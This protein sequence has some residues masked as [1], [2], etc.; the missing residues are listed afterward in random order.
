VVNPPFMG[1]RFSRTSRSPAINK[2]GTLYW[3]F[4]LA[5]G[6]GSLERAGHEV[7][8]LDC[9][10]VGMDVEDLAD[11]LTGFGPRMIVLD[12]STPSI[13][14]DLAIAS[15][16]RGRLPGSSLILVGTHCSALPE[17]CLRLAPT[18]SGVAIGEYDLTLVEAAEAL[19]GGDLADV[20]GMLV[21][22]D[23]ELV[24]TA[25]RPPISDLDSLPLLAD[26]YERHLAPEN[27]FFAAARYPSVMTI[28]SRGC[29]YRCSFC[30]W[31]Q[32]MH[33]GLY[34]TRSAASVATE[35]LRIAEAFPQAREVVV[36]DDTFS[37]DSRRVEEVSEA[38]LDA[39]NRLPWTANV[40]ATLSLEAM[41]KMK[42]A[43][44]RLIIVGYESGSQDVLDRVTKGTTVE[45]NL[46]FASRARKAGLMVHGCFMA[47]NPGET[48]ETL[49][50]TLAM[51][52]RLRPDTAQFFPIMAYPGTRLY[53]DFRKAGRIRTT[54]FSKWV[55]PE[56]LHDC[57]V[58]LPGLPAEELVRWCDHARKRFYLRPS[59][60][61]YKA[62]QTVAHPLTEG[63]RTFRSFRTF[64]KYL[65]RK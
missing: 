19:D 51:A 43:G 45:Q 5:Y 28:T 52:I 18:V 65:F 41:R 11:R 56:G 24:R 20:P 64:R 23:M 14:G 38:L 22:R 17:D 49:E 39:G 59:Y 37:A 31:P 61:C 26:V 1:G 15:L 57:V 48:R 58:D 2:S 8:F 55:T 9:P 33:R 54:D 47:G 60:L 42:A 25:E 16:L 29:P 53:D 30:V 44:C 21:N 36:E 3:P 62:L 63:R 12:T 32:V 13:Y 40:R 27:Y 35:F 46:E 10:A 50:Q 4:W 6:T 7:L 34:R